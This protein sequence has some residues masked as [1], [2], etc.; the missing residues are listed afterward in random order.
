MN[1]KGH[2]VA[3]PK[4]AFEKRIFKYPLHLKYKLQYSR[5]ISCSTP[6]LIFIPFWVVFLPAPG[7][8]HHVFQVFFCVPF[9][10]IVGLGR[11][12]IAFGNITRA[13][14]GK[15]VF[16]CLPCD[17]HESIYHFQHTEYR[18]D[19]ERARSTSAFWWVTPR[20]SG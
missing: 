20:R 19:R 15:T 5:N 2:V 14:L 11:V 4:N 12:G 6:D 16:D 3:E 17:L 13:T 10:D 8:A 7:V 1:D 18:P 9:Q